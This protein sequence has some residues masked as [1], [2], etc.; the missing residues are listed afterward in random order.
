MARVKLKQH[1][2]GAVDPALIDTF[3]QDFQGQIIL[4]DEADYEQ[5]RQIWNASIDRHP[6]MIARCLGTADI[7]QAVTFARENK[8]LVSVRGGGHNVAGRALCDDGVVIDLSLMKGVHVDPTQRT[9]WVQ[10]G[11]TLGD[12]DRE[13][14]LYGLAVPCGVISRTGI[15]GLTLGGGVGWLVRKHGLS[16]DNIIACEVVTAEGEL[17]TASEESHPDLFWGLR[18]GGGNFGIVSSF[19]FRAHPVTTVL[20]GPILYPRADAQAVLRH[21]R[22][23]MAT[24][25]EELTVYAGLIST[26]EGQPAT[27]I[28]ACYCGDIATGEKVLA[29][30][31][32]FGS[33]MAD[34]IQP[35]PFTAMQR[36]FDASFPDRSHNYWKS[37]FLKELGNDVIDI[38]ID[39]ANRMESPLSGLM[40]EF[41]GGAAGRVA[42][43]A[44]AF[45]QR[46]AEYNIG[47]MAQWLDSK[48]SDKHIR[49]VRA[50]WDALQPYATGRY[51]PNFTS[52][53]STDQVRAAFGSNYERLAA[54]KAKYDPAN[55]FSLNQNVKTR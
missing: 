6:G 42:P 49:L 7:M 43:A 21:Y 3:R 16:C 20:G 32:K 46:Q 12:M 2:G 25:P 55:F 4:P 54:V 34:M 23:F 5:A 28:V 47:I 39:Y 15:A 10:A 36:M 41:Y 53:E 33:P 26:P 11:A 8:L 18:G 31:R 29:P 14:A 30:L 45:A 50:A 27:A 48:E 13:T 24:A 19:L 22:D 40:L 44:T 52:D 51:L 17:V 38:A 9:V 1:D 35:L 37:A